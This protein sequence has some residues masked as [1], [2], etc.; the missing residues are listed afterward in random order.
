MRD[1]KKRCRLFGV[2][3]GGDA[4]DHAAQDGA[5]TVAFAA[6][7]PNLAVVDWLGGGEVKGVGEVGK[8]IARTFAEQR[9]KITFRD[10]LRKALQLLAMRRAAN[11]RAKAK[12]TRAPISSARRV[13]RSRRWRSSTSERSI[14]K[15]AERGG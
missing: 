7:H 6:E 12:E 13:A 14:G 4:F 9:T 1:C 15:E 11:M 3:D 2:N 8:L 5:G 10:A